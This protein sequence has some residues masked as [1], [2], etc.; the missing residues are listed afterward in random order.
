MSLP[1]KP[2]VC[3]VAGAA[4]LALGACGG[5]EGASGDA[6]KG[7]S[8]IVAATAPPD[9]LDPAL[10]RS[11]QVRQALWLAYTPPLTYRRSEGAKGTEL[12][13]GVADEL[14]EVSEDGTRYSFKVREGLRYS[15]RT[16]VRASDFE[17]TI[18]R[19][20]RL[21]AA[22]SSYDG[23]QGVE[24]YAAQAAEAAD[25][26]GIDADDGTREVTVQ[27]T[28]RDAT[29]EHKLA[30]GF[31]GMVPAA[32]A[33]FEDLTRSP[34]PG[35]GPYRITKS[36]P[37]E[38]VMVQTRGF[39]LPGI[40]EGNLQRITTRVVK[41]ESS[42]ARGVIAGGLDYMQGRVPVALLPEV[43]SKYKDRYAE[44]PTLSSLYF[45]LNQRTPPFDNGK[46]RKAVNL[47]LDKRSLSRLFAG[48]LEPRCNF[49]P[50]G[51]AAHRPIDPCPYGDPGFNGDPE[52]ARQLIEDSGEE[53]KA[54]TVFAGT[55]ANHRDIGRYYTRLLDKIGLEARLKVVRGL[56]GRRRAR[57]QTGVESFVAEIPHPFPYM[58]LLEGDVLDS[59][60]EERLV[61]LTGEPEE[62]VAT[63]GYAELDRL[64]VDKAYAAPFGAE[65]LGTFLSERMDA[66]NCSLFHP[67][68]GTDYSSLCLR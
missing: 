42:Q 68:Y 32:K 24:E 26:T 67:V 44:H 21:G 18:K 28:E 46:V 65:R 34:P 16:P 14:P 53:G 23:I 59:E 30:L 64:V 7:G 54:V 1:R 47:A 50:G 49:L 31:A 48:R 29:F 8:I 33:P 38:F 56:E 20:I 57:A 19:V 5:G 12:I 27:L 15:D 60:V 3:A 41:E 25:I 4:C 61:E 52:R 11:P 17:H 55:A 66:E 62:E 37:R 22:G 58:S 43:R 10:G 63:E 13:P 40:P 9:A 2:T 45:F 36:T 51:L 39:D 35:V 6:R